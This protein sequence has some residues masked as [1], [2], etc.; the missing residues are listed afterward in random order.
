M[1]STYTHSHLRI[2]GKKNHIDFELWPTIKP[3]SLEK[4]IRETPRHPRAAQCHLKTLVGLR[5]EIFRRPPL[6]KLK[7]KICNIEYNIAESGLWK[8]EDLFS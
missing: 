1:Q 7:L 4:G 5:R 8:K 3:S 2:Y 6:R